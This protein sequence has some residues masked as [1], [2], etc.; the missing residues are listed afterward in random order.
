MGCRQ[1]YVINDDL[2][3][4]KPQRRLLKS[5]QAVYSGK[6]TRASGAF[7]VKNPKKRQNRYVSVF[8]T[9]F[10]ITKKFARNMPGFTF[11]LRISRLSPKREVSFARNMSKRKIRWVETPVPT[12]IFDF[13][14]IKRF[15]IELFS[16]TR[17]IL[18]AVL[19]F[20]QTARLRLSAPYRVDGTLG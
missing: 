19:N 18:T 9:V 17:K 8:D 11:C 20:Y 10:P 12:M 15:K 2:R 4:R 7:R 5:S 13:R 6:S 14:P 16:S 3:K 1:K